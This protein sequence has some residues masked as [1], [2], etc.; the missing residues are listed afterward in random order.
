MIEDLV[1][2]DGTTTIAAYV[3]HNC[4][5]IKSVTLP[6]SITSI[7]AWAFEGCSGIAKTYYDGTPS[8]WLKISFGHSSANPIYFSHNLYIDNE[9]ITDFVIGDG[10]NGI[11]SYAFQNYTCLKTITI[12]KSVTSISSWAFEGCSNL[13]DVYYTSSVADYGKITIS[14]SGNT[15][16]ANAT[17]HF[18]YTITWICDEQ[19]Y[20]VTTGIPG[21]AIV[22]PDEPQKAGYTFE[23]WQNIPDVMPSENITIKG[24]LKA[25]TYI[26]AL[27]VDNQTYDE[28]PYTYGQES[29]NLPD[30]PLKAG[31]SGRWSE[32]SLGIDGTTITAIYTPNSHTVTWMVDG[33]IYTETTE[34]YKNEIQLPDEPTRD[35][36][37]FGGWQNFPETMPDEDITISGSFS[38]NIYYARVFVDG[39]LYREISYTYG[40]KSV[41]LPDVPKK[42]GYTGSWS[43]YNLGVGGTTINAIYTPNTYTVTFIAD[44]KIVDNVSFVYGSTSISEPI[45]PAKEGHFGKWETYSLGAQNINVNA[46]YTKKQYIASWIVNG[47]KTNTIVDYGAEIVSPDDPLFENHTFTGWTP[48]VPSTMPA[49][50]LEFTA[51]FKL[52]NNATVNIVNY[53]KYNGST[54]AYKTTMTFKA[55]VKYGSDLNWHVDGASYRIENGA[56][57]VIEAENDFS[58][59]CTVVDGDG[60]TV[61]SK[62]ETIK[63]KHSFFDKLLAF[64]IGL[65]GA[66]KKIEQ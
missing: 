10:P 61:K 13:T 38:A 66:F 21:E 49:K 1:I 59:Y 36:Y 12:P 51:T 52:T 18:G 58:V 17:K 45:V 41:D 63:I 15:Y 4:S 34:S 48:S 20:T 57:T 25:N 7:S 33:N 11:Q 40:Q 8:D 47:K 53:D 44:G 46:I 5:S 29:I 30:V 24:S 9:L 42:T 62:T 31:Y 35:G 26:A 55:D 50:N 65:F 14:D 2:P 19:T 64:F 54:Q 28:I 60:N 3:F 22:L 27:I 37:T 39:E 56:C 6:T 16:Y 32:Y 43:S 23:G